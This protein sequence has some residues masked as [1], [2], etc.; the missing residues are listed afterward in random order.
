MASAV[1]VCTAAGYKCA[2]KDLRDVKLMVRQLQWVSA[3]LRIK[4][5]FTADA[6]R[7]LLRGK[8]LCFLSSYFLSGSSVQASAAAQQ[9]QGCISDP[10]FLSKSHSVKPLWYPLRLFP[11]IPFHATRKGFNPLI[12]IAHTHCGQTKAC[13]WVIRPHPLLLSTESSFICTTLYR[14]AALCCICCW[15]PVVVFKAVSFCRIHH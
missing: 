8:F 1:I 2:L 6:A 15:I 11:L 5:K 13:D 10:L 12:F 14:D 4:C 3:H 9:G 7:A